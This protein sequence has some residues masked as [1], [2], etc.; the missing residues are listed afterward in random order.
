MANP[1]FPSLQ[2]IALNLSGGSAPDWIQLTPPGPRIAGRDGRGWRLTRPEA[3][4][5]AFRRAPQRPH[6]DIEHST[7]LKG[8]KG[9]P[10]PAVGWIEEM[11]VR[12]GALWGRVDWTE[13][14]RL[15]VASR[16]YRYLS[17]A[18]TFDPRT[19]EVLR[20]VSAGLTNNPNLD[21]AALNA[22][23][24][25]TEPTMDPAILEALG[26]NANAS[27]A[28]AVVA[29]G[30]LKEARDTALNS[31]KTPSPELFVPRADHQLA[32]NRIEAFEAAEKARAE[33]A[34]N[35]AVEA[36][37]V[38]G[39]I[40][41]ASREY[42]LAACHAEGGLARF[43]AAMAA[44]PAITGKSVLEGR[45]PGAESGAAALSA[46]ELA[47]CQMFNT[48]PVAFAAAKAKEA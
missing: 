30:K 23:D 45:K 48:D 19:A 35:Q 20:M 36:A 6:V 31:A 29:I 7:Q 14:G 42:H 18:F 8:P 11:E 41:P 32:L 9:E 24:E 28:D 40:A 10:A 4:V 25:E 2:G 15:A 34:I 16:A 13:E 39:K 5:E 17:P 46:D 21:M 3:V 37:I 26:L 44:T 38:A 47:V 12:E 27:A 33:T 1:T 22:A 43:E